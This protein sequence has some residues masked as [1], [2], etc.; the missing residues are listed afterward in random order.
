MK[1][2]V[3]E[4]LG[5]LGAFVVCDQVLKGTCCPPEEVDQR[6][7]DLLQALSNPND[8][9]CSPRPVVSMDT[10]QQGWSQTKE[11]ESAGAHGVH[12][13]HAKAYASSPPLADFEATMSRVP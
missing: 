2:R 4:E 10:F 13:G 3:A 12:F 11:K 8:L 7:R 9:P 5:L 1:G 6:T